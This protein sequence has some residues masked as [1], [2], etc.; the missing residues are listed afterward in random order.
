MVIFSKCGLIS[1]SENEIKEDLYKTLN[2]IKK[3][4]TAL[5]DWEAISFGYAGWG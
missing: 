2:N 1:K 4:I 3:K 5:P